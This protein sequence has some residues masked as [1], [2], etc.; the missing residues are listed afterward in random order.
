VRLH[1][2]TGGHGR[3]NPLPPTQDEPPRFLAAA[4]SLGG[5]QCAQHEEVRQASPA[6][7]RRI[8]LDLRGRDPRLAQRLDEQS[9]LTERPA[10]VLERIRPAV[11]G[12]SQAGTLEGLAE[13][14]RAPAAKVGVPDDGRRIGLARLEP[15]RVREWVCD[16]DAEPPA[17]L[18][19]PRS[20]AYRAGH[21]LDVHQGVV[22][23]DQVEGRVIEGERG[24]IGEDVV[25]AD[26]GLVRC[27]QQRRRGIDARDS[28]TPRGEIAR[29]PSLAAA[30]VERCAAERRQEFEE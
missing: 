16:A 26:V 19:H 9:R 18:E 21:V 14:P 12:H 8:A 6:L 24:R 1:K 20:L 4:V 28:V 3:V 5:L 10:V 17:G 23:N 25:A 11:E 15:P 22:R 13:V 27:A 29:Q 7:L 30:E 2:K